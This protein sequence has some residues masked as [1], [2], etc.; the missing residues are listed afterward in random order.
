MR[1]SPNQPCHHVFPG[2]VITSPFSTSCFVHFFVGISPFL[3]LAEINPIARS[4][5]PVNSSPS[6]PRHRMFPVVLHLIPSSFR[7]LHRRGA[8]PPILC[9]RLPLRHHLSHPPAL[10]TSPPS[11]TWSHAA[12]VLSLCALLTPPRSPPAPPPVRSPPR[13]NTFLR[14][15]DRLATYLARTVAS[16]VRPGASSVL[17]SEC[18]L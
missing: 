12:H 17:C 6:R 5:S 9:H 3:S 8:P 11:S 7:L 18:S 10:P 1:F 13:R 2:M 15:T 14:L 4:S 16:P